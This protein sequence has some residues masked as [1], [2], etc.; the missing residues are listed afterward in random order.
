MSDDTPAESFDFEGSCAPVAALWSRM[1]SAIP[2]PHVRL[3]RI[4]RLVQ[5]EPPEHLA[6]VLE[7]AARGAVTNDWRALYVGMSHWILHARPRPRFPVGHWPLPADELAP[8]GAVVALAIGEARQHRLR[9]AEFA[10]REAFARVTPRDEQLAPL[11]PSVDKL[12][13]G[14]RRERARGTD[15]NQLQFLLLDTTPAVV[16]ILADNPRVTEPLAVQIASLRSQNP[17]ALQALL[18][19]PRWLGNERVVEAVARNPGAPA[20]LILLVAPLLSRRLQQA[21]VHVE[22]LTRDV[23]EL[24]SDWHGGLIHDAVYG[25]GHLG[26]FEVDTSLDAAPDPQQALAELIAPAPDPEAD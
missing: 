22:W 25:D 20:W 9:F 2:D 23:R 21:L 4:A 17:Y 6:W 3:R 11:H 7:A 8:P 26:T 1:L 5:S 24:L 14:V 15:Q 18:M 12:A 16:Q 13:L 19:V 10:L